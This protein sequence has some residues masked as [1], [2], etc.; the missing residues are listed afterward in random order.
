LRTLCSWPSEQKSNA[1]AVIQ[2]FRMAALWKLGC[3]A[4]RPQLG[5]KRTLYIEG[6]RVRSWDMSPWIT[7]LIGGAIAAVLCALA[8][9]N[10]KAAEISRDGWKT[11]HPSLLLHAIFILGFAL[12]SLFAY[13]ALSG[14]S[15][16]PDADAQNLYLAALLTALA[17]MTVYLWWT[18]YAQTIA[19]KGQQLRVRRAFGKDRNW[20]FTEIRSIKVS[21]F[22]GDCRIRFNDGSGITFSSYLHGSKQLL[23]RLPKSKRSS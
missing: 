7:G 11:L 19:W 17:V 9:R 20:Q 22:R 15:S 16:L 1:R 6:S 2:H 10:Q 13:I 21:E 23:G 4:G 12:T 3:D 14:G 18:T 5:G 8:L